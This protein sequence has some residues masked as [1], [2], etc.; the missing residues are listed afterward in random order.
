ME[1]NNIYS[2]KSFYNLIFINLCLL[3]KDVIAMFDTGATLSVIPESLAK[4]LELDI[5]DS[6][7]AKNNQG[8]PLNLQKTTIQHIRIGNLELTHLECLVSEDSLFDLKTETGENF[9]AKMILGWNAIKDY[10]WECDM[11]HR[12]MTIAPGGKAPISSS[13]GYEGFPLVHAFFKKR[14]LKAGLDIGHTA[15]MLSSNLEELEDLTEIDTELLGL[16]SSSTAKIFKTSEFSVQIEDE[17]ISLK[18]VEVYP[19]IHGGDNLDV[20]FG[21]DLLEGFFWVMDY[22]SNYFKLKRNL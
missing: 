21:V 10:Y 5:K 11:V 9:P 4:A 13:L 2:N 6:V 3:D 20:L 19:D 18:D 1:S 8:K 17:L 15:T 16:G 12:K 7:I 14:K 22:K